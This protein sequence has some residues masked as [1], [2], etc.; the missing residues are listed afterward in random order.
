LS[1]SV[2]KVPK[3]AQYIPFR[4]SEEMAAAI[5]RIADSEGKTR[6]EV[7]RSLCEKGLVAGGYTS[8]VQEINATVKEAL[9]EVLHPAVERLAA[10]SAKAAHIAAAAFFLQIVTN[11][12]FAPEPEALDALAAK[13]RRL[14][15]EYL[16][17]KK[18][19]DLDDWLAQAIGRI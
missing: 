1:K 18:D 3:T 11:R 13:A 5:G 9:V 14:G 2:K 8:G 17:L 7:I 10:I 6:S 16:K 12:Q 15:V 19:Q 4:C